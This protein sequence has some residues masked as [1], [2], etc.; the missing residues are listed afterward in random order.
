M[1]ATQGTRGFGTLIKVSDGGTKSSLVTGSSNLR[2]TWTARATGTG[3]D[4]ITVA[5]STAGGATPV[6]SVSGNAISV[7]CDATT[8]ANE[9]VA[10]VRASYDASALVTVAATPGDGTSNVTNVSA[11]N[12]AGGVAEVYTTILEAKNIQGPN[13]T[14]DT[15]D[16]THQESPSGFKEF[17]A[18][19]KDGGEVSWDC[20]FLPGV[21][22]QATLF[23][24]WANRTLRNYK[25]VFP[26]TS[27]SSI[28]FGAIV[29][30]LG[31]SAPMDDVLGCSVTLKM[32]GA[33]TFSW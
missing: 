26:D 29:T 7:S 23:S 24:L 32:S 8:T 30:A 20:N 9:V 25:I 33:P 19:F 10:A 13:F 5:I 18:S 12:L 4:S 28:I 31:I 11:T 22:S 14:T 21:G 1:S 15:V 27:S 6:V 2:I 3:G 16:A 17:L